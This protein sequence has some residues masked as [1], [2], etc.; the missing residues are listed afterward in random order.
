MVRYPGNLTVFN[1]AAKKVTFEQRIAKM[2][3]EWNTEPCRYQSE[4]IPD[5][6]KINHEALKKNVLGKIFGKVRRAGC[7]EKNFGFYS[8]CDELPLEASKRSSVYLN[9]PLTE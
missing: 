9:Y 1:K 2:W 4:S 6:E 8:E 5:R 3:G 7:S